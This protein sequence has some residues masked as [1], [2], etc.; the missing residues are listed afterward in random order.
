MA[1]TRS[2]L[3]VAAGA[4]TI[5]FLFAPVINYTWLPSGTAILPGFPITGQVSPSFYL[6]GC[7]AIHRIYFTVGGV[8]NY[9]QGATWFLWKCK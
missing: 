8:P 4:L 7:G 2:L 9:Y 6:L 1:K 5:M 3:G